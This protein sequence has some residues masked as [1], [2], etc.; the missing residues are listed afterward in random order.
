MNSQGPA[1]AST[2]GISNASPNSVLNTS[3]TTSTMTRPT[4]G[5]DLDERTTTSTKPTTTTTNPAV[6]T[7]QGPNHASTTGIAHA[8][9][10]SVLAGGAVQSTTLP[11]L[12][13]GL[14]VVNSSGTTIG[15]V[16]QIV[17][18][19]DGSIRLVTVQSP[20]GQVYRVAPNTLTIN[21]TTV[22]TT[23]TIGG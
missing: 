2:T 1:N 17:Y 14:N 5:T 7:S 20:T 16:S 23:S 9:S 6:G 18:G 13:Q 12:T 15:T 11:G 8:N 19:N 4:R 22:T 10:H 3:G 21:G